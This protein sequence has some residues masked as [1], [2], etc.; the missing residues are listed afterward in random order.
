M[1]LPTSRTLSESGVTIRW[2]TTPWDRR[3][4]GVT[5]VELLA[6]DYADPVGLPQ[7]LAEFDR[8]AIA[9]AVGLATIRVAA[10]DRA[11]IAALVG[12]GFAHVETSHP[13]ALDLAA[14]D[15][16]RVF[17]RAVDV[18]VAGPG[19][20]DELVALARDG[21]DYSRFHEDAR[22]HPG[23]ARAR[24]A[25]WIADSLKDDRDEVWI[26][27]HAGAIAALMSF[28]RQGD[29]V[30]LLLGGTRPDAGPIAPLF[31]AGVLTRLRAEG[32][33]MVATRISAANPAALRLHTA[34]GFVETATDAGLTK[35]YP[36]GAL[37]GSPPD[38]GPP[39]VDVRT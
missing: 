24:F 22:I 38:P 3:S 26:H 33:T 2:H 30:Q 16:A 11:L 23:R 7:A 34:F 37:V 10:A 31:W 14:H 4:L 5:T 25:W 8:V 35:I 9:D 36:D 28:R 15:P 17:R 12:A 20:R 6:V 18:E 21:F 32:A 13:L 19:D 1:L 27:R 39:P 29:R